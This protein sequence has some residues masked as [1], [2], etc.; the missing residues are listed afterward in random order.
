MGSP[1]VC[2]SPKAGE[3]ALAFYLA[4]PA[5]LQVSVETALNGVPGSLRHLG[6][7]EIFLSE[8]GD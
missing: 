3:G 7:K 1:C 8:L 2:D 5:L 6:K 4:L